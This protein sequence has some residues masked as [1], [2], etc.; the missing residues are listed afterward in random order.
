MKP[1]QVKIVYQNKP[2]LSERPAISTSKDCFD[3]LLDVKLIMQA[4]I[5]SNASGIILSHNH[6]SG[7]LRRSI[8]DDSITTRLK[9][10]CKIFNIKL[11]DHLIISPYAYYSYADDGMIL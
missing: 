11:L 1:A 7:N 3:I 2:N 10:A 8:N 4:A 6:P 9:N 5:L